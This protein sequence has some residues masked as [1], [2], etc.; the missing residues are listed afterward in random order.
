MKTFLLFFAA[1]CMYSTIHAQGSS[2]TLPAYDTIFTK[3][4]KFAAYPG[5]DTAWSAYVKRAMKY[6]KKA[7]WDEIES[8]VTVKVVVDKDGYI[9]EA[10]HLTTSGSGFEK[11]A[12]RI[13]TE[14]GRWIPAMH[15]GRPVACEGTL[16]IEF[17]L[18]K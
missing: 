4:E 9:K 5:G 13:V 15:R 11:E 16:V 10:R 7:W 17:R 6:P 8:E 14:S 18:K 2:T 3:P 12:V 1:I